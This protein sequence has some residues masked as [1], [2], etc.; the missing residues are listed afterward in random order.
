MAC[1]RPDSKRFGARASGSSRPPSVDTCTELNVV[2]CVIVA[3]APWIVEVLRKSPSFEVVEETGLTD[4]CELVDTASTWLRFEFRVTALACTELAIGIVTPISS[5]PPFRIGL[6]RYS[7]PMSD[8]SSNHAPRRCKI[9]LQ[10][11][12]LELI[13]RT[14]VPSSIEYP[15]NASTIAERPFM[16]LKNI[17]GRAVKQ[18]W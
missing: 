8:A 2:E 15:K 3:A 16:A 1:A 13:P 6:V 9:E 12:R 5:A 18:G 11:G 14:F 4:V 7:E 10:R 17:S